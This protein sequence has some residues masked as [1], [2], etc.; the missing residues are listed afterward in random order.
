MLLSR[1]FLNLESQSL[2]IQTQSLLTTSITLG[3]KNYPSPERQMA[4]FQQVEARL[5]QLPGAGVVAL[6]DTLPPGGNHQDNIL[7]SNGGRRKT[8]ALRTDW[9]PSYLALGFSRV[10]SRL[11]YSHPQRPRLQRRRA[12]FPRALCR[13]E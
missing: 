10:F 13:L 4:F 9:R 11:E 1:S 2:G 5:R 6:S 8:G 3:Q 12:Q 7:C